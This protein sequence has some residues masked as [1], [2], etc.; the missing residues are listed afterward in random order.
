MGTTD[1]AAGLGP[2]LHDL[3][4]RLDRVRFEL[5]TPTQGGDQAVCAEVL[6]SIRE[7]LL[8]RLADW[9]APILAVVVGSTGSGKSTIVNS[10]AGRAVSAAGVLRPTTTAPVVWCHED[11]ADRYRQRFVGSFGASDERPLMVAASDDPILHHLSV[12]DAP[13]FDSVVGRHREMAEELLAAADVAVFVASAQRYADAVPWEFLER[14]KRRDLTTVLVLNRVTPRS[15]SVLGDYTRLLTDAG[16]LGP[17]VV[18]DEQTIDPTTGTLPASA[19]APIR[20][21]L[22]ALGERSGRDAALTQAIAGT[23]DQVAATALDVADRVEQEHAIG[24]RLIQAAAAPYQVEV[25]RLAVS[26]DEGTLIRGEVLARWE[27]FVGTGELTRA[28]ASGATRF[29]DWARRVFGGRPV[30]AQLGAEA[31]SE[32]VATVTRRADAASRSAAAAWETDATGRVLLSE[33][34]EGAL[35]RHD[36]QTENEARNAVAEWMGDVVRLVREE[37]QGKKKQAQAASYGV[38]AAAV[39]LLLAV[40]V[41]T[42]GITGAELGIAAG[43]AAAQQK[44]LEHVFGKAAARALVEEARRRLAWAVGQV[45]ETD[46]L[47]FA[48]VVTDRTGGGTTSAEIRQ[49]VAGVAG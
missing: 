36:P 44:I 39:V 8:P 27:E 34:P 16:L 15:E 6:W 4:S 13:D 5:P 42:A 7:Y 10:M 22:E 29:R 25:A 21:R 35:W 1:P 47:R 18:I 3:A 43:A 14:L 48:M 30:V 45:L 46:G 26:L 32:L 41:H 33:V 12:V 24:T 19:V 23:R 9:E 17:V 11:N 49:G 37:G 31:G 28:L 38:N 20:A 40:F 2:A